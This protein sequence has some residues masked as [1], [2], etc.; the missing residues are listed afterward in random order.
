M[1]ITPT[2]PK[3]DGFDAKEMRELIGSRAWG[4]IRDR[5]EKELERHR[6]A[7][8]RCE[9]V[10]LYRAQGSAAALRTAL[11]LPGQVLKEIEAAT[12]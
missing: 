5:L 10:E 8:E 3:L 2:Q 6:G 12:K 4:R 1:Q 7:C 11:A 9:G